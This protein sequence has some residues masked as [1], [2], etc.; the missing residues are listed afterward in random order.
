LRTRD[1]DPLGGS[2]IDSEEPPASYALTTTPNTNPGPGA[3][4]P[5]PQRHFPDDLLRTYAV[6]AA[7]E[8]AGLAVAC[9]LAFCPECRGG[10]AAHEE[11]LDAL[12]R[13]GQGSDDDGGEDDG[14]AARPGIGAEPAHVRERLM[15][16]LALTPPDAVRAAPTRPPA[17]LPRDMPPLPPALVHHLQSLGDAGWRRLVPG[18]RAIDLGIQSAWRARL[19]CFRPGVPIPLHDHG[20]PEHTVVFSGGLD[21]ASG[22]L[23]R[24]DAATMMPGDRHRQRSA[25]GEP[26][27]ALIVNE[28][29]AR[30]L[31]LVGRVLK[32]LTDS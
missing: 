10:A 32:R 28:A 20:G 11:I 26:C 19:V 16:T 23:G 14:G 9:H 12:L 5:V 17:T 8:G 30:P 15:S 7:S 2:S 13:I 18:I 22:H 6:G 27:V 29:P 3:A 21:D 1:P 4:D 24:G 25:P 31:T